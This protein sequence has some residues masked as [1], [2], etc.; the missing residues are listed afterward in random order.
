MA[1]KKTKKTTSNKKTA[2]KT[3]NKKNASGTG[4]KQA[5]RKPNG[6]FK[7]GVS[8]NPGGRPKGRRDFHTVVDLAYEE[9]KAELKK[10]GKEIEDVEVET[11]KILIMKTLAGSPK[12]QAMFLDRN[13]GKVKQSI[14]LTGQDG[15]PIK[16]Q[17]DESEALAKVDMIE[18]RFLEAQAERDAKRDDD[19]TSN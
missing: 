17:E 16:Y 18:Q 10:K 11:V 5:K 3:V 8:G 9:V 14:E 13:Y 15:G 1:A 12:H 2:K 6:Q 7:K 4:E 19:N